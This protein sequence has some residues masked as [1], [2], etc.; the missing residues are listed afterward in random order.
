MSHSKPLPLGELS[1]DDIYEEGMP[2]PKIDGVPIPATSLVTVDGTVSIVGSHP[3]D[4]RDVIEWR[5]CDLCALTLRT[6]E[7]AYMVAERDGDELV[8]RGAMH[9]R[10]F[11]AAAHWCPHLR[12]GLLAGTL[13]ACSSSTRAL[14]DPALTAVA[15]KRGGDRMSASH[16]LA[17]Y[18]IS[19]S[20][21]TPEW[22]YRTPGAA[23]EG[24]QRSRS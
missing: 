21:V 3:D 2:R 10:C 12:E 16:V 18:R 15:A 24:E 4:W 5:L 22:P 11:I 23:D 17:E 8:A 20:A 7:R 9:R 1:A 19:E 6:D 13:V 14:F